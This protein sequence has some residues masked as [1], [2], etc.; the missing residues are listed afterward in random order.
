M[1]KNTIFA[2]AGVCALAY[3]VDYAIRYNIK[4]TEPLL[5]KNEAGKTVQM[6]ERS[7]DLALVAAYV[8]S[9]CFYINILAAFLLGDIGKQYDTVFNEHMISVI[10]ISAIGLV[11]YF[12]GLHI[13]E[14]L[15]NIGLWVTLL[16]VGA[17][18]VVFGMSRDGVIV[19][20]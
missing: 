2:M 18:F 4:N 15:E 8:I 14:K 16:I 1:G 6:S 13:L 19:T 5:K 3:C 7:S 17:L 9:V 10:I 12:K 11:G 20:A